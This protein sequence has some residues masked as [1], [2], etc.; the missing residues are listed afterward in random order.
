MISVYYSLSQSSINVKKI[1]FSYSLD[2]NEGTKGCITLPKTADAVEWQII[3][4][5]SPFVRSYLETTPQMVLKHLSLLKNNLSNQ[6]Q[7]EFRPYM[8]AVGQIGVTRE[9]R[10]SKKKQGS[11]LC[12]RIFNDFSWQQSAGGRKQSTDK[13]EQRS[14]NS[15]HEHS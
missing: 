1:F 5:R 3:V 12:L 6:F 2:S 11:N 15:C 7:F 13:R 14:R 9:K 8:Y 4:P 10:I